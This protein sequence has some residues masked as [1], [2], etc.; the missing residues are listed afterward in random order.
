MPFV[1]T[2]Q[3]AERRAA[4]RRPR[5]LA[6]MQAAQTQYQQDVLSAQGRLTSAQT[7][8]TQQFSQASQAY[9]QQLGQYRSSL[10][11]YNQRAA[12]YSRRVDEYVNTLN[13]IEQARSQN[14]TAML[15]NS[16]FFGSAF[17]EID[18]ADVPAT[19]S[20][21]GSFTEQFNMAVPTAPAAPSF[22]KDIQ[23]FRAESEQAQ[24]R[25]EREVGERRAATMR[26]RRRMTDRPLL[27]EG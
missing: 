6:E 19:P 16:S 26:A 9:E 15:W 8:A 13:R 5:G 3:M 22:E 1:L 17:G 14:I 7:T 27:S 20:D 18:Y 2:K 10:D 21:P 23:T 24:V 4:R 12:D 25:M 11:A